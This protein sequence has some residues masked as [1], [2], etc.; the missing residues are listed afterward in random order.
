MTTITDIARLACVSPATVS[1]VIN[2]KS[3]V[4]RELRDRILAL[5]EVTGYVPDSAARAMVLQRNFTIGIVLPEAINMFQRQLFSVIERFLEESGYRSLFFLVPCDPEGEARCLQRIRTERL[6]GIILMHEVS[7]PAFYDHLAKAA[8]PVVL[9][10][11]DRK[12]HSFPSVHVDDDAAGQ[13]A[14]GHLIGLGHRAIGLITGSHCTFGAARA[15]GYRS[16]LETAGIPVAED[17]IVLAPAYGLE[18][19]HRAMHELLGRGRELTALFAVTDELAIGALRALS[20]AGLSVPGHLSIIGIDDLD[21]SAYLAP[22]LTTVRQLIQEMGRKTAQVVSDLIAGRPAELG[23]RVF[24][25]RLVVRES[26]RA[27]EGR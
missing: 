21:I 4:K 16:A 22:G 19:G 27:L 2:Q 9:C 18:E 20:E 7:D 6:D 8:A 15:A 3:C 5:V 11:F 26:T 14:T 25:H 10:T 24:G 13:A 17:R 23:P 12:G 1:R